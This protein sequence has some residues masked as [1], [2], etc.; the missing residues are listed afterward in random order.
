VSSKIVEESAQSQ[1]G[2]ET[3]PARSKLVQRLLDASDNLPTFMED[4]LRN[5]AVLV[6]GTEAA[7]FLVQRQDK[8]LGLQPVNHI[9][10]DDS[11]QEVRAAALRAFQNIV[12]PCVEQGKDGAIEVGSPDGGDSQFCLVTLLRNEGEIVAVTAVITRCRDMERAKQRLVSMQL[13]AGYFDLYSLRRYNENARA[14]ADRHQN[15]LQFSAAIATAEGFESA[16]MGLCNELAARTGATRVALGWVK[17]TNVKVKALSHTEKFDKKQELVVQIKK[18]M[19]ECLDQEEPVKFVPNG[20]TSPNVTRCAAELSRMTGGNTVLSV[21]LRRRDQI[22]G[23]FTLE[24]PAQTQLDEQQEGTIAVAA[25]LLG[26]PLYDRYETDRWIWVKIG[27][28]IMNLVKMGREPRYM[29]VKLLIVALLAVTAFVT[30]YKPMYRVRAPFQLVAKEKRQV[31]AP[32]K[33]Q[34]EVVHFKPGQT[35]K[36]GT[37]MA[38]MD[39]TELELQ[40]IEARKQLSSKQLEAKAAQAAEGRMAEYYIA[41]AGEQEAKARVD[42][43]EWQLSRAKITAPFDCVVLRGDWFDRKGMPVNEGD[44][45]FEVAQADPEHPDRIA[46]EVEALVNERDIQEVKRIMDAQRSGELKRDWDGELA[47]TALPQRSFDFKINRIVPVGQPKDGENV[48]SV[49]GEVKDPA[50]WMQPGLAGESRINIENR[51]LVWIW[52]HRL[53]DWLK[54]KLWI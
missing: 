20:E 27:H 18:V 9:R 41:K 35:V 52:T 24:F 17:G 26:P 22:V 4:L 34:I 44:V 21:P 31:S 1:K 3:T 37:V 6:A 5:Q 48:F 13:V 36:K 29:G 38:E 28:S 25:E 50:E 45:L 39:T 12:R 11:D 33:G 43:L 42:L 23:V 53:V 10:P 51:R 15:V 19:E 8:Q 40:L 2:Q 7:A 14:L 46:V 16:A 32:F 30:F 49:Y 47:S 54:L